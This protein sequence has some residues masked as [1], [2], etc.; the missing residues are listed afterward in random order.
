M[1]TYIYNKS[2][3]RMITYKLT[4]S[5][6]KCKCTYDDCHFTLVSPGFVE[7]WENLRS[8]FGSPLRVTSGF[9]CQ[10]HNIDVGG[11]INSRHTVG[12]AVDV[13]T[14]SMDTKQRIKLLQFANKYFSYVKDYGSFLHMDTREE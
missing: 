5:E 13:S 4:L 2:M 11:V 9:R 3:A 7:S 12:S 1:V 10:M 14:K 6:F 8:D